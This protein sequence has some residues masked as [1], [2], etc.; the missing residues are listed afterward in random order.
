MNVV[1]IDLDGITIRNY[2]PVKTPLATDNSTKKIRVCTS[3]DTINS[4][5]RTHYAAHIS[6]LYTTLEW[7]LIRVFQVL[8]RYLPTK[9]ITNPSTLRSIIRS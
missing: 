4:V 6:F 2:V 8:L 5:V 3:W 1:E 7:R 9:T